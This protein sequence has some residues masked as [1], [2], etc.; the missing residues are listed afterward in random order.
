MGLTPSRVEIFG[1]LVRN[2]MNKMDIHRVK[3]KV[4]VQH[5]LWLAGPKLLPIGSPTL[6]GPK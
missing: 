3:A 5:Y 4:L 2:G 6:E 1:W